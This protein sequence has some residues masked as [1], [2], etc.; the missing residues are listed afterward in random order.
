MLAMATEDGYVETK[1]EGLDGASEP[2]Y[3]VGSEGFDDEDDTPFTYNEDSPNLVAE[4][5]AHPKGRKFL[6]ECGEEVIAMFDREYEATE[7]YRKRMTKDWKIFAGELPMKDWPFQNAANCHVPIVLENVTR[8]TFRTYAE[9]FGNWDNVYGFKPM[10]PESD[11]IAEILSQHGNWQIREQIT[12]FK[13]QQHRGVLMFYMFGDV[14]CHSFYDDFLRV[15][16][17]EMITPE[18]FVI[19]Y[20][21]TSTQPDYSDVPWKAKIVYKYRHEL[22]R[23]RDKWE[24]ID[25]VLDADKPDWDTE[26]ETQMTDEINK[27]I[28]RERSEEDKNAPYKII[29][30]E[31]WYELP[32]QDMDRY[33][34]VIVEHRSKKVLKLSF[35][36]KEDWQEKIRYNEQMAQLEEFRAA[37][38]QYESAVAE[39]SASMEAAAQQASMFG[40]LQQQIAMEE[41]QR[42]SMEPLEPPMPPAWM[43]NPDDPEEMP[44]KPRKVPINLF[45]HGVCIEPLVGNLGLS[46]GRMEADFNRAA[47]TAL[48]QFTD[49]AT[50]SNVWSFIT[51]DQTNFESPFEIAPGKVNRVRN[52]SP[53]ELKDSIIELKAQPANPQLLTI[54]DKM[55]GYGQSA[56]QAPAALSGEPGKSGETYR[57]LAARLEQATKQLSVAAGKY[58]DFLEQVLKNNAYLN[59]VFLPD[60]EIVH[61]SSSLMRGS[62]EIRVGRWMYEQNYKIEIRADLRFTSQAQRVQ[63]ADEIV[64]QSAQEPLLANN[65]PFR[66]YAI[67]KALEARG[68][69]DL[70][71]LMGEP[72]MPQAPPTAPPGPGGPSPNAPPQPHGATGPAP[73]GG[74][75]PDNENPVANPGV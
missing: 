73:D 75:G 13:R 58:K 23:L 1:T 16:R 8:L 27:L 22:Q 36:E 64:M 9:L 48:S 18:E 12:D 69:T 34:Q 4:F 19:P 41:L 6:K 54:V 55:V 70:I 47:N 44:V 43:D 32:N 66:W 15:N 50:L 57:G 60:E 74:H 52:M 61:V 26:P 33:C 63:E 38:A 17:H 10:G 25:E 53:Q 67:K 7:E 65:I 14:T 29:W 3:E 24:K 68:R 62:Q 2:E 30:W 40:P 21:Y 46:Y 42:I 5:A 49:S 71:E 31:G 45:S 59:S 11:R 72:P 28:G 35:H 51:T 39:R 37:K 56:M 20:T